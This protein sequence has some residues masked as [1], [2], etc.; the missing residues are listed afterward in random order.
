MR[1]RVNNYMSFKGTIEKWKT[2]GAIAPS[3]KFLV[4]KMLA[5]IDYAQDLDLLQLGFGKGVFTKEILRRSTPS[6]ALTIFEV[7]KNCWKYKL[8]SKRITYIEDSAEKISLYYK[9]KKFDHIISTLPF[10][11]L[12]K[13]VSQNIFEEIKLHLKKNGKFLQFQYSL[14]SRKDFNKLF[15]DKPAID[16][17]LLNIPPAFIY[18]I[19]NNI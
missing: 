17:V 7:D 4:N 8:D 11:S 13:E 2:T 5:K 9:D 6:S 16:F 18:E 15:D 3:S 10:A 14:F 19:K 1:I 12:P